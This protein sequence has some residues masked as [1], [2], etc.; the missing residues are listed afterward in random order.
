MTDTTTPKSVWPCVN[1]VDARAAIRF[2][3]EAFGFIATATTSSSMPS[4]AGRRVG[5]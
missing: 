2:L 4:S 5:E 1:Y 3:N